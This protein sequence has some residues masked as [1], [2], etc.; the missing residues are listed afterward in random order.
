MCAAPARGPCA[1][2]ISRERKKPSRNQYSL[3]SLY[4]GRLSPGIGA[5]K[6]F[7]Q[8]ARSLSYPVLVLNQPYTDEP[9]AAAPETKAW[10][11]RDAGL[12]H[13]EFCKSDRTERKVIGVHALRNSLIPLLSIMALNLSSL[14]SGAVITE[15]VF[16]WPGIGRM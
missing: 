7:L 11:D 3:I 14:F 6:E 9:L 10:R 2:R 8:I 13:Q 12:F 1:A 16:A 5:A 15:S 4:I